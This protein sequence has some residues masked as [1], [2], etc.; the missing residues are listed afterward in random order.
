MLPKGTA[1]ILAVGLPG[2]QYM[3]YAPHSRSK[4]ARVIILNMV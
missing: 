4:F 2:P 3:Q 1:N